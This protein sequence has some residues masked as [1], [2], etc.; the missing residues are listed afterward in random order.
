MKTKAEIEAA[1]SE[2]ISGFEQEYMG[3]G[4]K[5]NG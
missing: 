4:P 1:I 5:D 2:E 3:Q